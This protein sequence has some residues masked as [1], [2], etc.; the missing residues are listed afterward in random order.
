[1]RLIRTTTKLTAAG[2]L[3]LSGI[4]CW[5]CGGHTE[6]DRG[7]PGGGGGTSG[8]GGM[9]G[10]GASAG[11][12][13]SA[14]KGGSAGGGGGCSLVVDK[15]GDLPPPIS[16]TARVS[17]PAV[18]ATDDGF[19]IGYRDQDGSD[20]RA[21]LAFLT[22]DGKL[23]P[24]QMYDLGGC[25]SKEPADG[26]GIAYSEG[27]GMMTASLPDCG[28]GAGAV[29]IPFSSDGQAGQG[30]GPRNKTF[31]TLWLAQGSPIAAAATKGEWELVY[32]VQHAPSGGGTAPAP[33]VER[34]VLQGAAF[35]L[36]V[37]TA[38]PFGDVHVPYGM[39]ATSP[40]VRA[41]LAP[42]QTEGGILTVVKVGTRDTDTPDEKGEFWL[43]QAAA[44]ATLTVWNSRIAAGIPGDAGM[45]I[46]PAELVND[47]VK[48][49]ALIPV[50]V[51][52]VAGGA[53]AVLRSYLLV[54]QGRSGGITV[55]RL[56]GA[57]A[58]LSGNAEVWMDLPVSLGSTNLSAFDG[59]H[60]AIA[61]ARKRVVVAWL[62][63]SKLVNGNA[64][65]GWATL[66]CND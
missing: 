35:K 31:K 10:S 8:G 34:V 58:S 39:V 23:S 3:V 63:K 15:A 38:K 17:G 47:T 18:A 9:S 19:V 24:A 44:W 13:A 27:Y 66:K 16:P 7:T 45:I 5:A 21:V 52:A 28:Q 53:M 41:F 64:T 42:V 1:M 20:S 37:P 14:G 22:D 25:A 46:Q 54:A 4:A 43:P 36:S 12:G 60:I 48:P 61:A 65:G 30:A 2:A 55:H 40:Q 59:S 57:D 11:T 33:W 6:S 29:F 51:G 49:K 62:S 56:D 50:G 32:R 26:V